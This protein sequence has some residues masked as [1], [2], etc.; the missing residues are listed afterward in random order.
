MSSADWDRRHQARATE[1]WDDATRYLSDIVGPAG[2]RDGSAELEASPG[3]AYRAE[4]FASRGAALDLACGTGGAAAWLAEAGWEVTGVDFSP[5]A[6]GIAASR[7]PSVTWLEADLRTWQAEPGAYNLVHIAYLH[8]PQQTIRAV[9]EMAARDAAFLLLF[10][11]TAELSRFYRKRGF[12]TSVSV[13]A[14]ILAEQSAISPENRLQQAPYM[15]YRE[16]AGQH[17]YA[18]IWSEPLFDF[19][20]RECMFRSGL[21]L[22]PWFCYP[23]E[24]RFVCKPYMI[25]EKPG[26]TSFVQ[27]LGRFLVPVPGLHEKNSI[28]FLPLD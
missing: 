10:P 28:F 8:L 25:P 26:T 7:A 15:T 17:Q 23:A 13:P 24:K 16:R 18:F 2:G 4:P 19:A 1:R 5:V 6:L 14:P 12:S 11:A 3:S 27:A 20:Y 22:P 21:V 9:L